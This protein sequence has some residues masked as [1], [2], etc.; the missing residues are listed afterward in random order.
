VFRLLLLGDFS[1]PGRPAPAL[2]GRAPVPVDV[3]NFEAVFKRLAPR[4]TLKLASGAELSLAFASLDD[5]HADALYRRLP[6]FQTLR[7]RRARLM[8]PASFAAAAAQRQPAAQGAESDTATLDRLLGAAP[9]AAVPRPASGALAAAG[10]VDSLLRKAV[11]AQTVASPSP[12]REVYLQDVERETAA[13]MRALLHHPDFQALEAAWLGL[14]SLVGSLG[15]NEEIRLALLDV[16][17]EEIKADLLAAGGEPQ[18][19]GLWTQL[20]EGG[21]AAPGG[22]AWSAIAANFAFGPGAEDL[23]LLA[24][25]GAVAAGAGAPFLAGAAPTLLGISSLAAQPDPRDWPGLAPEDAARWQALR[26]SALAPWIGLALPR[27]LL[28]LPYG[29]RGEP[30]EAFHFEELEGKFEHEACLWGSPAF[31]LG[32]LLGLAFLESGEDMA[33]D[34]V[35]DLEDLPAYVH[36]LDGERRLLP[37]AEALLGERATDALLSRGLMPILSY[38]D[39]NAAKLVRFQSI[40]DPAA[41]LAGAWGERE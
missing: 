12:Q 23:R 25:L 9:A 7:D 10:I 39:R 40:A 16:S 13:Q 32:Q 2:A 11:G 35:T 3:D 34:D 4:L 20:V 17:R 18:K 14:R 22:E 1:G 37:C 6:L 33:P 31:A 28:R 41:A 19:M 5:F 29:K 15:G 21:V 38:R 8:D 26:R 30:V 36:E 27:I 24:T